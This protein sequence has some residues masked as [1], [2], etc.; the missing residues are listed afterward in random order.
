MHLE[1]WLLVLN[2]GDWPVDGGGGAKRGVL[3]A[4]ALSRGFS[5]ILFRHGGDPAVSPAA[6][7]FRGT[8]EQKRIQMSDEAVTSSSPLL[9]PD[10]LSFSQEVLNLRN[11]ALR[12]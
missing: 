4:G 1:E 10:S 3:H 6:L 9:C 5:N 7:I 12:R 11:G 8:A 2:Q